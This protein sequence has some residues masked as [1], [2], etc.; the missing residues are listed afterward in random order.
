[1]SVCLV[2]GAKVAIVA[3]DLFRIAWTQ[4]GS[5]AE[6]QRS[7]DVAPGAIVAHDLRAKDFGPG[8]EPL[9]GSSR[10]G[11]WYVWRMPRN[12]FPAVS[13]GAEP[14]ATD[15]RI[16]TRDHCD[17]LASLTGSPD[18]TDIT[19][20]PCK[21]EEKPNGQQSTQPQPAK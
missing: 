20:I 6:W 2:G 10:D 18:G 1:M 16:C 15:W 9:P 12:M 5:H 14:G 4:Q 21:A 17:A 13:F 19:A 3:A 7:Y 8:E 11:D